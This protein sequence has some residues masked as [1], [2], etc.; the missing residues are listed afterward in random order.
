M[1]NRKLNQK[2]EITQY[3][4]KNN[5]MKKIQIQSK[6]SNRIKS[7]IDAKKKKIGIHALF[8]TKF[9]IIIQKQIKIFQIPIPKK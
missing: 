8:T 5:T 3:T 1:N 4:K 2:E 9:L 6:P 7:I